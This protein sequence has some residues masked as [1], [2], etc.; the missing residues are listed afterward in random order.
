MINQKLFLFYM[1]KIGLK[2][3]KKILQKKNLL[4]LFMIK[5]FISQTIKKI[6]Q[7]FL[8]L[9]LKNILDLSTI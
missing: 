5:L 6:F 9:K 2:F 4:N 1:K 3:S 7:K 8:L